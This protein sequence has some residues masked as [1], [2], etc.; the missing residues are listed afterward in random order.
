MVRSLVSPP[1][2]APTAAP[3]ACAAR[4]VR[5][6]RRCRHVDGEGARHTSNT[7]CSDCTYGPRNEFEL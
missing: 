4:H 6:R 5:F 7:F 2:R 1:A 3:A